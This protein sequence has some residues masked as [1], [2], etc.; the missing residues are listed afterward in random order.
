MGNGMKLSLAALRFDN[1]FWVRDIIG[2][3]IAL[4]V[5]ISGLIF[6]LNP[7]G[8]LA[9]KIPMISRQDWAGSRTS[10]GLEDYSGSDI[11]RWKEKREFL[12]RLQRGQ[13]YSLDTGAEI[14]Q[15]AVWFADSTKT[16]EAWQR[17]DSR[18]SRGFFNK[19]PVA[20][21]HLQEG[22]PESI[23]FCDEYHEDGFVC[24]YF[25]YTEHWYTEVWFW[26]GGDQ[27]L[28]Y[29]DTQHIIDRVNQL[30]LEAPDKP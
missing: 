1:P 22:T 28:S 27:Y 17:R 30:L 6:V 5:G 29:V 12:I 21:T 8:I 2:I 11:E 9:P 26:S 18:Q 15:R 16:V 23:L 13:Y 3:L 4:V 20:T 24:A 19:Q 25:A 10:S 14:W 7:L